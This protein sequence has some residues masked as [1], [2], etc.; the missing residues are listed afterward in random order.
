VHVELMGTGEEAPSAEVA[1]HSL[2]S[3]GLA[4]ILALSNLRSMAC[5]SEAAVK[6]VQ[7]G[8]VALTQ[9]E[10]RVTLIGT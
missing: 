3:S 4:P 1:V 5:P 7:S 2:A 6:R 9:Q 8:A 10:S